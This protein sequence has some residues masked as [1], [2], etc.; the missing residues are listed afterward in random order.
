ML[1]QVGQLAETLLAVG[2]AVRFDAQVNPQV[3]RQV[4]GVGKGLGAVRTLVS[5][6][7]CVRFGVNLHV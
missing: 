3:L 6:C 2:A 4:G 7:L 5:L 1:L